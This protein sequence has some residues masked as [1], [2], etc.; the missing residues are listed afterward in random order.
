MVDIWQ[1]GVK[2]HSENSDTT[3]ARIIQANGEK[4]DTGD[5]FR[6]TLQLLPT[7]ETAAASSVGPAIKN[8]KAW[9]D[10][11]V[12]IGIHS[13]L[14]EDE[15]KAFI[16]GENGLKK[17]TAAPY[18]AWRA[19][20]HAKLKCVTVDDADWDSICAVAGLPD[21][22]KKEIGDD[23]DDDD[24]DDEDGDGGD[25]GEGPVGAA[26]LRGKNLGNGASLPG[27]CLCKPSEFDKLY[28]IIGMRT[29]A[30]KALAAM[31][32]VE[33]AYAQAQKAVALLDA[34]S[35]E[36]A[37]IGALARRQKF[38]AV[39]AALPMSP[40]AHGESP[41]K[42]QKTEAEA[43]AGAAAAAAAAASPAASNAAG[44]AAD[45]EED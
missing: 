2:K 9:I 3:I 15:K 33:E 43:A 30:S 29:S 34:I 7:I 24:G 36:N 28:S 11:C 45:E 8:I 22:K 14:T 1:K 5:K 6:A 21:L 10:Y 4:C 41:S 31:G 18:K 13:G 32:K 26:G 17:A 27:I 25:G 23:D 40:D 16:V 12:Q 19:R 38:A 39:A 37:I 42:K 20:V 44:A 35:N